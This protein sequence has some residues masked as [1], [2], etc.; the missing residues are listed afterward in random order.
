MIYG[1]AVF[2]N[3]YSLLFGGWNVIRSLL[4]LHWATFPSAIDKS[5]MFIVAA[6]PIASLINLLILYAVRKDWDQSIAMRRATKWYLL[7]MI[8]NFTSPAL[9]L[10][11]LFRGD[12]ILPPGSPMEIFAKVVS[13]AIFAL[14]ALPIPIGFFKTRSKQEILSA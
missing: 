2:L 11:L 12:A 14:I 3:A 13:Y 9:F 5:S 8:L 10:I 7:G 6:I 1:I 4:Y